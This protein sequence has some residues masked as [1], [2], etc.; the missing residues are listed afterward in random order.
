VF[1]TLLAMCIYVRVRSEAAHLTVGFP[2]GRVHK[3]PPYPPKPRR[4]RRYPYYTVFVGLVP[5]IYDDWYAK[6][7]GGLLTTKLNDI[8]FRDECKAQ[9]SGV[10]QN[11]YE[12]Y[13]DRKSAETAYVVTYA[14]GGVRIVPGLGSASQPA[15]QPIEDAARIALA[16]MPADFL[17]MEWHVVYK[18]RTPGIYPGW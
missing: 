12:G 8:C 9:V 13:D 16:S 10:S 4:S 3:A 2:G 11:C 14:L 17:G 7:F 1:Y 5:G 18:G 15:S 6:F